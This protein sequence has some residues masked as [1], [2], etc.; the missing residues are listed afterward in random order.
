MASSRKLHF[1]DADAYPSPKRSRKVLN[2]KEKMDLIIESEKKPAPTQKY[3]LE[4]YE[5]GRSSV[6]EIVS[7]KSFYREQYE[8]NTTVMRNS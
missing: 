5:I 1:S 8:N 6:S 2:L 7:R 3:L 4:K